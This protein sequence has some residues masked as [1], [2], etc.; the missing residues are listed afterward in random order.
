MFLHLLQ[1]IFSRSLFT[2]VRVF[3][4]V[5]LVRYPLPV[6]CNID[7]DCLNFLESFSLYL[8]FTFFF[9][10]PM[11]SMHYFHLGF[12]RFVVAVFAFPLFCFCLFAPRNKSDNRFVCLLLFHTIDCHLLLHN[13]WRAEK[14]N[15]F[16]AQSNFGRAQK[17]KIRF[18]VVSE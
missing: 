8:R 6:T 13:C 11:S 5:H 9:I 15:T 3:F 10:P 4:C 1:L 16:F 2:L 14:K 12:H 18:R 17:I 7:C